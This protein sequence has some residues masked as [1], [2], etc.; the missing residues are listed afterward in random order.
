MPIERAPA[1]FAVTGESNP[2][3][4]ALQLIYKH[5]PVCGLSRG[6]L[7]AVSNF[8]DVHPTMRVTL[9]D[10]VNQRALSRQL[11]AD[12]RVPHA[13]PQ[14]IF[15]RD[16]RAEWST[17]H[18]RIS[19]ATLERALASLTGTVVPDGLADTG[20]GLWERILS[21]LQDAFVGHGE[22]R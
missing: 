7:A 1:A 5:S 11:A 4:S 8:A 13:S 21:S 12:L 19:L 22:Y 2:D 17:S 9:I 16:G 15:V 14:V 20:L 6:A 18:G 10:V 3:M